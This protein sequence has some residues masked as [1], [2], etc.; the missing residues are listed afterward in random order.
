MGG[1]VAARGHQTG[2]SRPPARLIPTLPGLRP[3]LRLRDHRGGGEMGGASSPPPSGAP[4]P[5]TPPRSPASASGTLSASPCTRRAAPSRPGGRRPAAG[6]RLGLRGVHHLPQ[7]EDAPGA[8]GKERHQEGP[9]EPE[10]WLPARGGQK[11]DRDAGGR[12]SLGAGLVHIQDGLVEA[13]GGRPRALLPTARE[14]G[15]GEGV[16]GPE[17]NAEVHRAQSRLLGKPRADP[18]RLGVRS[19][20]SSR[21]RTG[22]SRD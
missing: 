20:V 7:E 4:C 14:R 9:V 5:P 1:A 21:L 19:W 15:L 16:G 11:G 8:G 18:S 2:S 6:G 17:V 10:H 12:R 13:L 3:I 22:D